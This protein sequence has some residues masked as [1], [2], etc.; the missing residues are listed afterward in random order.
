MFGMKIES[1]SE[2]DTYELGRSMAEQ[3]RPGDIFCLE[4]D[5]GVGK[6]VFAK[7]FG[8]GL[9]I[10]EPISSPTFTIVHEYYDGRLT[11]YHFDA[12]RIDDP[13]ELYEIGYDEYF[14]GDGVCLIEWP[15]KIEE[16][17]PEGAVYINIAKDPEQGSDYREITVARE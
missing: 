14:Y 3:A 13:A 7:G 9:G 10:E 8:R 16:L 1:H 15:S 11:L 2:K 5:L 12:Y 6:T 17:I 4:G